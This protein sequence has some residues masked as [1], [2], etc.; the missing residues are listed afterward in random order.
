MIRINGIIFRK[1]ILSKKTSNVGI[2]TVMTIV[3]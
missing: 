3:T 2:F 1:S